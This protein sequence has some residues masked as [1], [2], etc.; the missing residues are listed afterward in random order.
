MAPVTATGPVTTGGAIQAS[1]VVAEPTGAPATHAL[2][3]AA[4]SG[5]IQEKSAGLVCGGGAL[6]TGHLGGTAVYRSRQHV[7]EVKYTQ[8]TDFTDSAVQPALSP[9]GRMLAFVRGVDTFMTVDQIY[10][11]MLP[12]GE[13]RKV[14]DDSRLKYGLS[15]SPDGSEDSVYTVLEGPTFSTY[16]VSPLGGE[17]R[18]MFKNSAGLAW[19]DP[20]RVLFSQAPREFI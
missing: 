5:S 7:A 8:L 14:T 20:Q 16:V 4:G 12:N 13:A 18:L 15:F 3:V 17:P 11:K 1:E 6:R 2:Q 9:D 19:L 10:V